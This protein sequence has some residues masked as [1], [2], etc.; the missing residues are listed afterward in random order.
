MK[1]PGRP[2]GEVTAFST[3]RFGCGIRPRTSV[4][5][6]RTGKM[7]TEHLVARTFFSV[8]SCRAC[9]G[10]DF[11]HELHVN[12]SFASI[13]VYEEVVDL[14]GV[15]RLPD[16]HDKF[17]FFVTRSF[18][19]T[20]G[21]FCRNRP[22]IRVFESQ[23]DSQRESALFVAP[24]DTQSVH[25]ESCVSDFLERSTQVGKQQVSPFYND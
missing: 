17:L 9:C 2:S 7:Q 23:L 10:R 16:E 8:L 6:P 25:S 15:V 19:L 22:G 18:H 14:V 5:N 13:T 1:K 12:P 21:Y 24:G 20:Y 4:T 11:Y 3:P